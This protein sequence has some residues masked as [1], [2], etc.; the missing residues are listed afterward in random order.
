MR[1]MAGKGS[2]GAGMSAEG[3]KVI[4]QNKK[5]RFEYQ[6]LETLEAGVALK[7]TEVKSLRLG[8][9]NLVD[10]YASIDNGEVF[11]HN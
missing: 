9:A 1:A 3:V 8:R 10:S 6:I 4:C 2:K 7:G 11:M 5:A